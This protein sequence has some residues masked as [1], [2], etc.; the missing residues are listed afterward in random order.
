MATFPSLFQPSQRREGALTALGPGLD[1]TGTGDW[2]RCQSIS[3]YLCSSFFLGL[4]TPLLSFLLFFSL[5]PAPADF[6][7][8]LAFL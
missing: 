2:E 5:P 4:S 8:V 6:H 3:L 7:S 1:L